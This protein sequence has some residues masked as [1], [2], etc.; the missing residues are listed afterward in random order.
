MNPPNV[1]WC[2]AWLMATG[3]CCGA[4]HQF[5]V[6]PAGSDDAPGTAAAPFRTLG[7]A[8]SAVRAVAE[9]MRG[10]VVVNLAPG[11]YR[12]DR[13][14]ELTEAD[15]GRNG[16]R[17]IYHSAGGP[18]KARLLGSMPL[19]GWQTHRDRIWKIELPKGLVFHTLYENGKRAC[20]ARF[21]NL[22]QHPDM[23]TARGRYLVTVDG[24]PKLTDQAKVK[25]TGP[26]WLNYRPEDAPPVTAVTKMKLEIF[27]GGTCDWMR[28]IYPV[29][30]IDPQSRRLDFA[31]RSL[32]FGV[33]TGARFFLEDELGFLDAPGEFYLDEKAHVLYY[34]PMGEGH[35]DRLG[36][37]APLLGRLVQIRGKSRD[38]CAGHI[39]LEGLGLEET[40]DS[41]PIGWWGTQYG[42]R[43]G[44]L[45]W[46]SNAADVEIRNCHL[47]SGGRSG[48]MMI[49]H[50][51]GN[52]VT[53]CWIEGMGVNGVTL[54][55]RFLAPGGKGPTADR[56][57][58]N[59]VLNNRIRDVGQ[60]HTYAACVN[61]FNCS[62]NEVGH[63]ELVSSVRYAVTLRGNTGEQYGPPVWTNEPSARGN[64][65]H[66]LRVERCGQ[67]GG[68]MGALHAANLNNPGGGCVNTFEQITVADTRAIPSMKDIPPDG[69]FL[70]WPKMAMDQVFRNVQIVR[71]QGRQIR[72]NRPENA[73]SARTEN[74]SWKP[75]F[76]EELMDYEN[77]GLTAQ[78]PAEYGGRPPVPKPLP[79]P[80]NVR[81]KAT[82][83]DR[84][85]SIGR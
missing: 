40:D 10:D 57:E 74:V 9:G 16:F 22:E 53:G 76:R 17:V 28:D 83:Y 30:S 8:Q 85:R 62:H 7:R 24:T 64:R 36:I 37:A 27:T 81:A 50:N 52:L 33:G 51:L 4:D 69:I 12:M 47:K 55:N 78:F 11:E 43:D 61:V 35:P 68:D 34:I 1:L 84:Y 58:N 25:Q 15:S 41:P 13:T 73:D 23:P 66:H 29:T 21:P 65:F 80:G 14:L 56:C 20:K 72:S 49:G 19:V 77:I 48:I 75:G 6:S 5:Y 63:C 60:I 59:R 45:I 82:A 3:F 46:I 54:C 79:A 18:G 32:P 38:Q 44:A 31:A 71:S 67:D 26:G 70:D 2:A 42:R 39:T